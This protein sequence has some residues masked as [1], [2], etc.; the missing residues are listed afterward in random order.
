MF[1]KLPWSTWRNVSVPSDDFITVGPVHPLLQPSAEAIGS[2]GSLET[3]IRVAEPKLVFRLE[4][5]SEFVNLRK[6]QVLMHVQQTNIDNQTSPDTIYDLT[7]L[8]IQNRG[9]VTIKLRDYGATIVS[10][11]VYNRDSITRV[12]NARIEVFG[13]FDYD[14]STLP[15]NTRLPVAVSEEVPE[16]PESS[17]QWTD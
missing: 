14:Y 2:T 7:G 15:E 4:D 1:H 6:W 8:M 9:A 10:F 11:H 16:W 12:C 3:S 5:T 17:G 13:S